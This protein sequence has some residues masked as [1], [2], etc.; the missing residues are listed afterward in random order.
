MDDGRSMKR[1]VRTAFGI[2]L[3]D[4]KRMAR[5]FQSFIYNFLKMCLPLTAPAWSVNVSEAPFYK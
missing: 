1:Q 5:V 3:D 2:S 4:E